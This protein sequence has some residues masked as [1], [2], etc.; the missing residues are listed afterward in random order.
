MTKTPRVELIHIDQDE[1][2]GTPAQTPSAQSRMN[3][4][5]AATWSSYNS[6]CST[7]SKPHT[8]VCALPLLAA[9]AHEDQC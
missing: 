5:T 2:T 9:P 6:L 7:N 8:T 1:M 4:K 3:C